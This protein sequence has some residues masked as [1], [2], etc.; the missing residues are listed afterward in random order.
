MRGVSSSV[1]ASR[2]CTSHTF[3]AAE[4]SGERTSVHPHRRPHKKR[5]GL[6]DQERMKWCKDPRQLGKEGGRGKVLTD[7]ELRHLSIHGLSVR[8]GKVQRMVCCVEKAVPNFHNCLW[9]NMTG[10]VTLCKH[11]SAPGSCTLW[12]SCRGWQGLKS[13][14]NREHAFIADSA[15]FLPS[16]GSHTSSCCP[17]H[18]TTDNWTRYGYLT[19]DSQIL[20]SVNSK[21]EL[22][23]IKLSLI[24]RFTRP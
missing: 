23:D 5:G 20:F 7:P 22:G 2:V 11:G 21:L 18:L 9:A 16:Y 10:P 17:A 19:N 13:A 12:P 3:P 24:S 14:A 4:P 8:S 1:S 6:G 15:T